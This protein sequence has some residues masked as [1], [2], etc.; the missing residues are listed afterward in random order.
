MEILPEMLL[1]QDAWGDMLANVQVPDWW[2]YLESEL[3]SGCI[4][5]QESRSVILLRRDEIDVLQGVVLACWLKAC[6]CY[7]KQQTS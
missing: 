4:C 5:A 1:S 2:V 7:S 3:E 6:M